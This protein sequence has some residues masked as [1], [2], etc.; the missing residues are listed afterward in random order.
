MLETANRPLL[1]A[2]KERPKMEKTEAA[3]R[4]SRRGKTTAAGF[5]PTRAEPIRFQV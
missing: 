5:E 4:A 3:K 2:T 1:A